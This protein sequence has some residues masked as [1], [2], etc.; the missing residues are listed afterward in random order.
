MIKKIII[1]LL[2]LFV[3]SNVFSQKLEINADNSPNNYELLSLEELVEEVFIDGD[4]V[5]ISSISTVVNPSFSP[6]QKNQKNYGYFQRPDGV[7]FPFENGIILSTGNAHKIGNTNVGTPSSY[8][9]G[10]WENVSDPDLETLLQ[11]PSL[12]IENATSFEFDFV[13][14]AESTSFR[15]I[16]GSDEYA[17]QFYACGNFV[18]PFAFI[19]S[20]PGI[21]TTVAYDHDSKSTTPDVDLNLGGVNIALVPG[22]TV[23]VKVTTIHNYNCAD[24]A[25]DGFDN[26]SALFVDN[27]PQL[28]TGGGTVP[29]TAIIEG[30]VPGNT[31]HLKLAIGDVQ[32]HYK[33]SFVLLE[34]GGF[35]LQAPEIEDITQLVCEGDSY[36]LGGDDIGASGTYQWE[37]YDAVS[38]TWNPIPG[39]TQPTHEVFVD[40]TYRINYTY[41]PTCKESN[42]I[43]VDFIP[44]ID[45]NDSVADWT[46][47]DVDLD[48]TFDLT[49]KN[50]EVSGTNDP[51]DVHVTYYTSQAAMDDPANAITE[52]QVTS[53]TPVTIW[54]KASHI[55][56]GGTVDCFQST[57]FD[58]I[59]VQSAISSD[60]TPLLSCDE[61]SGV[62][63][64]GEEMFDL[65]NPTTLGEM[66]NGA[67]PADF[68]I[69]YYTDNALV[70]EILTPNAFVNTTNPQTI[71]ID[72]KSKDA[73][74]MPIDDACSSTIPLELQVADLPTANMP[75]ATDIFRCESDADFNF[76]TLKTQINNADDITITFSSSGTPITTSTYAGTDGEVIQ[77]AIVNNATGCT[78]TI[79]FTLNVGALPTLAVIPTEIMCDDDGDSQVVWDLTVNTTTLSNGD[80]YDVTYHTATPD[81]SNQIAIPTAFLSGTTTVHFLLADKTT[82]CTNQGTFEIEVNPTPV[83]DAEFDFVLCDDVPIDGNSLFDLTTISSQI[84]EGTTNLNVQFYES[85]SFTFAPGSFAPS[86]PITDIANYVSNT[87]T[88]F[89]YTYN[90]VTG[91]GI[92]SNVNLAVQDIP[93]N[94]GVT[95]YEVCDDAT[96]G[97]ASN[98]IYQGFILQ[99]KNDEVLTT[100]TGTVSYYLTETDA[101]AGSNEIDAAAPFTNPTANSSEIWVRVD[102]ENSLGEVCSGITS[103]N[104]VVNPI[105]EINPVE[106]LETCVNL[107]G[108][109]TFDLTEVNT[110]LL[111]AQTGISIS[112]FTNEDAANA[113][114][115]TVAEFISNPSSF[116]TSE[117]GLQTIYARLQ[118]DVTNCFS[119]ATFELTI[120]TLPELPA[121]PV[122]MFVCDAP[123]N[124]GIGTFNLL[125]LES[126]IL[127]GN[128]GLAVTGYYEDLALGA[129]GF[130]TGMAIIEPSNF[131]SSSKTIYAFIQNVVTQCGISIPIELTVET[132]V[133]NEEEISHIEICDDDF[134]GLGLFNLTDRESEILLPG[135]NP[136]DFVINY[137]NSEADALANTNALT[138]DEVVNYQN[139]TENVHQ[140][141]V[142]V[143]TENANCAAYTSFYTIVHPKPLINEVENLEACD[144]GDGAVIFDLTQANEDILNEQLG[145]TITYFVDLSEANIGS[146][147]SWAFIDNPTAF[148]NTVTPEQTI[149]AHLKNDV[150][151]CSSVTPFNIQVNPQPELPEVYEM[152]VCDDD[153]N[154]GITTIYLNNADNYH[155]FDTPGFTVTYHHEETD[156]IAN[157]NAISSPFINNAYPN[158]FDVFVRIE[159]NFTHCSII[160]TMNVEIVN[161]PESTI[162][163][164]L[165]V[166]D[167]NNDGFA[168]FNLTLKDTEIT[169]A[170]GQVS[171]T[172]FEEL[173][174]AEEMVFANAI[175]TPEAYANVDINTQTVYA[176]VRNEIT[177]CTDIVA[178][179]LIVNPT[180]TV[181]EVEG[182]EKCD[183]DVADGF[184]L[185]DLT[186]KEGE[187][188]AETGITFEYYYTEAAAIEGDITNTE[189][190]TGFIS[191]PTGF[192]NNVNPQTIWVRAEYSD[193]NCANV[194]PLTVTVNER[195]VLAQ[196]TPI[197]FCDDAED[198]D[199]TNGIVQQFLLYEKDA[200]ILN[201]TTGIVVYHENSV[202]GPIINK[203]ELYENITSGSQAVYAVVTNQETGC[204]SYVVLDL[205]VNPLPVVKP[206]EMLEECDDDSDGYAFFDLT[207]IQDSYSGS[208]NY[209]V[210]FHI[211]EQNAY[212][213]ELPLPLNYYSVANTIYVRVENETTECF[214]VLPLELTVKG[215]PEISPIED[216]VFCDDD[217]DGQGIFDLSVVRDQILSDDP[218][219]V[220]T[221]YQTE[222]DAENKDN[223]ID[224]DAPFVNA[225]PNNQTI[226]IRVE[227]SAGCYI[228]E[229]FDLIIEEIPTT[230]T[231]SQ[232]HLCDDDYD[233]YTVFD[234]SLKDDEYLVNQL[235]VTV[236]YHTTEENAKNDVEDI[237]DYTSFVNTTVDAQE[238]YVRVENVTTGCFNTSTLTLV[239]E[240]LPQPNFNPEALAV[241]DDNSDGIAI[242]DLTQ[243]TADII[244]GQNP[245][246]LE[247]KYYEDEDLTSEIT[248]LS[249]YASETKTI[250]VKVSN[251]YTNDDVTEEYCY[252]IVS[253]ELIVNALPELEISDEFYYCV[254]P[255]ETETTFNLNDITEDILVST[256][257]ISVKYYFTQIA[258][259]SNSHANIVNPI[260]LTITSE[261][262]IYVR[263]E[264]EVTGC[265]NVDSFVL[266]LGEK[267]ELLDTIDTYI[268]CGFNG[269][270]IFNFDTL[271]FVVSPAIS[272]VN[273]TYY[274]SEEDAENLV[275]PVSNTAYES[276]ASTIWANVQNIETGCYTVTSF[277][278]D[279]EETP[280]FETNET[281]VIC[282][283]EN[284]IDGQIETEI[285]VLNPEGDYTYEWT[286][287]GTVL[288]ATSEEILVSEEG[289]YTVKATSQEGT[290]AC[291]SEV[292]TIEVVGSYIANLTADDIVVSGYID[293]AGNN[294][295]AINTTNLNFGTYEFSIDGGDSW[296]TAPVFTNVGGGDYVLMIRNVLGGGCDNP[297]IAFGVVDFP[298]Y[299]TPNND[300]V[301]DTWNILG[302]NNDSV[303]SADI[304]IYD[305]YGKLIT[306]VQKN[307]DGW[308][309]LTK[310]GNPLPSSDYWFT[311]EIVKKVRQ[312]SDGSIVTRTYSKKGHFSLI[313][314]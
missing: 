93:I 40:G 231:Q 41:N 32:D 266:K 151:G 63:P 218:T 284:P 153:I 286:Y 124:D 130:P 278:I 228:I 166:C 159:N 96:D 192:V 28:N 309:G 227:N 9:G 265:V 3:F 92:T 253:L 105:P 297:T 117:S 179:D 133:I 99:D 287:N 83:V 213:D 307:S 237:A 138:P 59:L 45:I 187:I 113:G 127:G 66:L 12:H 107:S 85:S 311:L 257:D 106:N 68:E 104:L 308:N 250:Y 263:V 145:I 13:A 55:D 219:L 226:W 251:V 94:L 314:R 255:G 279:V 295:I 298:K 200:E 292:H 89:A 115:E 177:G 42:E 152:I 60:L 29:M 49:A 160:T 193:T 243:T 150:T 198:G 119:V 270:G 54:A 88:I 128:T 304:Y 249:S 196:P 258:A 36:I 282:L 254:L 182:L 223:P 116:E 98:G 43:T 162:P 190:G 37:S 101:N 277:E 217:T 238:L 87:K 27:Y 252:V 1:Q 109:A 222:V 262:T 110:Q 69:K 10:A 79:D 39:A 202:D 245:A 163:T 23:P 70:N 229:S 31:Y 260:T 148:E 144:D 195:P 175:D 46:V 208:D 173:I 103:F 216:V 172:Y 71:Y 280:V 38:D 73:S 276:A 247:L 233:G 142:R 267:P 74:G 102:V 80:L 155:T 269:V 294:T 90:T 123:I 81:A 44:E 211:T 296:Q 108:V 225:T 21:P 206:Q 122:T 268:V 77:A 131:N 82:G 33:D 58:L 167:P 7:D 156:A 239:V 256:T 271:N 135:A 95:D 24:A 301:H 240:P 164:P 2:F 221:M 235:G 310:E 283:Y 30:L 272:D 4:C 47:C 171:V 134:D 288:D 242:F 114:D 132:V 34:G 214:I 246:G 303:I 78:T 194:V 259:E 52:L 25:A 312:A 121:E 6:T 62:N 120:N 180:P 169:H 299:F 234:L 35:K 84:L 209:K 139:A 15:Y 118:N 165:N 72:I 285:S 126:T 210:S 264:N 75:A 244:N 154:D 51:A 191:N 261:T 143:G 273:I 306:K 26:N 181:T 20:G 176:L 100:T 147:T 67:N 281:E 290:L 136:A 291:E 188:V 174:D 293:E 5:N 65:A 189:V 48:F 232:L 53:A 76:D 112:Y 16:F 11:S 17:S 14:P 50:A 207:E 183:D 199:D 18:D 141:W 197:E 302:L 97:D 241:C 275:N 248:N 168:E 158:A 236:T 289:T 140:V 201:G 205:I 185:F 125:S 22:K 220:I 146:E 111:G 157:T 170:I 178:L 64:A 8:G 224:I 215:K 300:G 161:S 91:C 204:M 274:T 129:D 313:R 19:L 186:I 61:V 149:Y 137:Y 57:S 184:T 56:G 203:L 212:G 230:I 86:N 305:R